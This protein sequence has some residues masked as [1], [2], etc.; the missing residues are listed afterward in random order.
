MN[1][2]AK[3]GTKIKLGQFPRRKIDVTN[4][5]GDDDHDDHEDDPSQG[6]Q[7]DGNQEDCFVFTVVP[8]HHAPL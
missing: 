1:G 4:N 2:D 7:S 5:G 8:T 3:A 6:C